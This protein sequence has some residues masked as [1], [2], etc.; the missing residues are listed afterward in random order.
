MGT[1]IAMWNYQRVNLIIWHK[2]QC[3]PGAANNGS[4]SHHVFQCSSGPP[5]LGWL[6]GTPMTKRIPPYFCGNIPLD[7]SDPLALTY[8]W[9]ITIV[10]Y[11]N[12]FRL[13]HKKTVYFKFPITTGSGEKDSDFLRILGI[14]SS[15]SSQIS[16]VFCWLQPIFRSTISAELRLHIR[17]ENSYQW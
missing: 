7:H 9:C 10:C 14:K 16:A 5:W 15:L 17:G 4:T 3:R 13:H 1:S 12:I 11:S 2:F 6:Q 8:R